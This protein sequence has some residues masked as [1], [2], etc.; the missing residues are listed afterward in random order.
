MHLH[1]LLKRAL[2]IF[3]DDLK[4][5]HRLNRPDIWCPVVGSCRLIFLLRDL[6][7]E[8]LG[9]V[10]SLDERQRDFVAKGATPKRVGI[11]PQYERPLLR[12]FSYCLCGFL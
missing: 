8:Q 10:T 12:M 7:P 9:L 5:H 1:T 3:H 2:E 6:S 11:S 4:K